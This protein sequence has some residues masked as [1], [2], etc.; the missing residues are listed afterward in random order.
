MN[1]NKS[2]ENTEKTAADPQTFTSRAED[3]VSV[4]SSFIANAHNE[5]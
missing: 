4:P 2:S 3:N 1:V 5:V